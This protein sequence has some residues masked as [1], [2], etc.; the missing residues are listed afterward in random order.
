MGAAGYGQFRPA[1][2]NDSVEHRAKNRRVVFFIKNSV[3]KPD[4]GGKPAAKE[5][6]KAAS[7]SDDSPAGPK[8]P[9]FFKRTWKSVTQFFAKLTPQWVK[10]WF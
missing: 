2:A 6:E 10:K 4:A 1:V 8:K 3:L 7:I 9:G 5:G